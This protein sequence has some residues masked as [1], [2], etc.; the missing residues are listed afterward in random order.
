MKKIVSLL[1]A[2][3]MMV[4]LF[5]PA[6]AGA[7][8]EAEKGTPV[9][10]LRGDGNA[11]VNSSGEVVYPVNYDKSELP[12]AVARVLNPYFINAVLFGKWEEYY[13][14]FAAEVRAIFQDCQ[15]DE[16]GENTNGTDISVGSYQENYENMNTDKVGED[17]VY[18]LYAYTFWYDWRRDP[19][20]IADSLNEYIKN[21]IKTT[22]CEKVA[23]AGKCLG[24]SFVLAYLSKYGYS[25]IKNIA[26]DATV[27]NGSEF[28]SDT[29][30]G[31]I[32][33]DS[34]AAERYFTDKLYG[35]TGDGPADE[36]QR[37]LY[38]FVLASMDL[39]SESDRLHLSAKAIDA[40]YQKLYEGLTPRLGIEVYGTWPGY[41]ST[42]T[43]E[44]Y[45]A[46][47]DLVFGEEGSAFYEKYR[48]LIEK[49]DRY[50]RQVRQRIPEILKGA[51]EAGLG[52]GIVAKYGYQAPPIID[53]CDELSDYLVSVNKAS[54]GATCSKV[55]DT[56]SEEYIAER[57][58]L[59][60][61]KYISPDKQVD[62]STCLFPD[63]TWFIKGIH[64]D[65][66]AIGEDD[67]IHKI[68]TSDGQFTV[69]TDES[70]PQFLVYCD[71]TG[72]TSAMTA[73]NCNVTVWDA[74]EIHEHTIL[75]YFR[76]VINL[77]KNIFALIKAKITGVI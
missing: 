17:G 71:E 56:L 68:C 69:T 7:E 6:F 41:W 50:D 21:I 77:I 27:G 49:L 66:W 20:E 32:R 24:G 28:F 39:L 54:F 16:N 59:G 31:K 64:H 26:F 10:F 33:V 22:G 48:G 38:E 40:I 44:N 61:E 70:Y 37:F 57:A 34:E 45:Q 51:Q 5:I 1:L 65:T 15:L 76:A 75:T 12:G 58:T 30:G 8:K 35:N 73:E 72:Y 52:V 60:L 53:S 2:L 18:P 62:A 9:V 63:S 3:T 46:A 36:A 23:L 13:D 55:Y 4:T 25:D 43:A 11:I 19:L 14:A 74:P 67:I 42:A 29:F 47:R